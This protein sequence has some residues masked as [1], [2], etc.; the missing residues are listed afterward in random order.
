MLEKLNQF[1][2]KVLFQKLKDGLNKT[3][4]SFVGKIS[5][6]FSIF[7]KIDDEFWDELEEIMIAADVG[8]T[9]TEK[10]LDNLKDKV[11]KEKI[12]EP[13]EVLEALKEDLAEIMRGKG[14]ELAKNEDGVTVIMAVGVNGTGKT[15]SIAKL[16]HRLKGE[17]HKVL[18]AAA[19]TFRAAAIDQLQI[20]A[21]RLGVELIKHKDGADPAAVCFDALSAAKARHSDY[22]I[23]DTAG[24]LHSKANLME[25]LRKV[26]KVIAREVPG[27]PHETLLVLDAT[28][29]QNALLQAKTF[30]ELIDVSGIVLTKL[31]GTAKG[32]IVIA[33]AD[34]LSIPVKFIGLGE[35]LEDLRVF[36]PMDFLNALF[37]SGD[38]SENG[39]SAS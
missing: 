19:D 21:S 29:G 5:K 26:R 12:K 20:W 24:R 14:G 31:D 34:E 27:A 17:G 18:L 2:P 35:K 36:E 6:L 3:R 30:T 38:K 7:K 32:G 13:P 25:E 39:G 37:E 4:E 23:I 8:V 33:I 15:T 9:T 28:T 22:C 10:L 1:S 11:K 16:A